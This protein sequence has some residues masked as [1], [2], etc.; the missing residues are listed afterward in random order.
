MGSKRIEVL[1]KW[2]VFFDCFVQEQSAAQ[3]ELWET[4]PLTADMM[5]SAANLVKALIPDLYEKLKW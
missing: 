4:R 2:T 5:S 3:T 1:R